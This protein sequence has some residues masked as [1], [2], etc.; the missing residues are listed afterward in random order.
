M[1]KQKTIAENPTIVVFHAVIVRN[2]VAMVPEH[3]R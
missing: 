2:A 1:R 3:P